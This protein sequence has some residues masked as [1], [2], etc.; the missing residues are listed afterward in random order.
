MWPFCS[1]KNDPTANVVHVTNIT[2]TGIPMIS[3]KPGPVQE[4]ART[5]I[6]QMYPDEE[7]HLVGRPWLHV[8]VQPNGEEVATWEVNCTV[9]SPI[10][11]KEK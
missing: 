8:A 1:K 11:K 3:A 10:Q 4:H 6:Q 5:M 9:M 2:I 7:Q